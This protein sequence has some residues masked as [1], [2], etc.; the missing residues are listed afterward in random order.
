LD[1]NKGLRR[2]S[3]HPKKGE[4]MERE[5]IRLPKLGYMPDSSS[6]KRELDDSFWI[7]LV[8][9]HLLKFYTAH[10]PS[11]LKSYIIINSH[12]SK[13]KHIEDNIKDYI[14]YWFEKYDKLIFRQ[15]IVLNLEPKV[16]YNN[17]GFYDLKFQ[18]SDWVNLETE[19]LKYYCFECKNLYSKKN[20]IDEYVLN[21]AKDDGGVFRYFNG[22]YAQEQS[23]GGLLGFILDDNIDVIKKNIIDKL[24]TTF[25]L[26]KDGTLM[27]DGIIMNSIENNSF[28]FDSLHMRN[29]ETFRLHH[30]LFKLSI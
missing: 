6:K 10:N 19:K 24:R 9:Y 11:E 18:H 15:G 5:Y 12:K 7:N 17:V 27:K 29:G 13:R 26:S 21:S 20:Y 30:F 28:T 2:W 23:F 1:G 16:K 22:K 14:K 25:T 3:R 8:H 4:L